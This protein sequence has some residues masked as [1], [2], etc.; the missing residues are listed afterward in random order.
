MTP[1]TPVI[2]RPRRHAARVSLIGFGALTLA[3]VAACGG[4]P[5]ARGVVGQTYAREFPGGRAELAFTD[6][7]A[8]TAMATRGD[9]GTTIQGRHSV[10]DET[11]VLLSLGGA[12]PDTAYVV[13]DSLIWFNRL[14]WQTDREAYVRRR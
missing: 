2:P 3:L 11:T 7:S 10:V 6:D 12:P 5:G 14:G 13:D 9:I 8:F 1:R 4:Q